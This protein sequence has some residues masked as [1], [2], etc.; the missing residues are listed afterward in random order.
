LALLAAWP[1]AAQAATETEKALAGVMARASGSLAVLRYTVEMET[2]SRT[3]LGQAVC[4]SN[5]GKLGV[6]LTTALDPRLHVESLKKFELIVP[7]IKGQTLKAKLLGIDSWTG[8][9]LVQATEKRDWQVVS[10]ALTSQLA[11]S[12]QVYSIGLLMGDPAW[13]TYLGTAYVSTTLRVPGELVYVIGGRLTGTCSPVFTADGRAIGIVGRQLFL[14]YEMPTR[15]G[16]GTMRMRSQQEAVFF[17]PVEEFAHVL[18]EHPVDGTVS[19]LPW[20]GVNKFEPVSQDVVDLLQLDKPAVRIDDVIPGHP[21][22]KGGLSNRDVI[23]EA[24]GKPIEEMATPELSVRNFVRKL[25]RMKAGETLKLKL[26]SG[27][28]TKDVT[29]TLEDMPTRP[30]EAPRYF[31]KALG[32]L[33]REKVMLDEYLDKSET[34]RVPGLVVM[35]VVKASPA[36]VA[37]IETGDLVTNV[38]NQPVKTVATFKQIVEGS[39]A[40]S[41]T[42][43]VNFLVRREAQAQLITVKPAG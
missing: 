17:T 27:R 21:A 11:P 26:L 16:V 9:G 31:N 39:L 1:A 25:M 13:P 28:S 30:S 8:L 6:F 29:V 42:A 43:P 20:M 38:N 34:A 3:V 2:G 40:A 22:A 36:A 32:L 33:V 24:D 23:I 4:V 7:G 10:F 14:A 19:R 5:D 37:G 15:Q 18:K 35:G 41:R 12:Q